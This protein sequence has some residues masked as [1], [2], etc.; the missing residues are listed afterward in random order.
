MKYLVVVAFIAILASLASALFFMMRNGRDDRSKSNHMAKALAVRVGIS[1][2]LFLCILVAW[3][4]GYI[5]P[6]GLPATTR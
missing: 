1:I 3:Q 6:T 2:V 4:L 5:Q